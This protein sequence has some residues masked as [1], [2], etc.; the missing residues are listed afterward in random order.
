LEEK[1]YKSGFISIIG[2]PN[3]GKSE[4]L[5][6]LVGRKLSIISEKPQTTRNKI[7]GIRN[8]T[9][10]QMIFLD[11]P[12]IHM[13]RSKLNRSM[14]KIALASYQEVDI[15]LFVIDDK[16]EAG[17]IDRDVLKRLEKIDTPVFLVLN[18]IDLL[19]EKDISSIIS[20]YKEVFSFFRDIIPISALTGENLERLLKKIDE[21]LAP[22]PQYFPDDMLTDRPE[23]FIVAELIREKVIS[24]TK[25]EIPYAVAIIVESLEMKG[26]MMVIESVIFVEKE[27]QKGIIIGKGGKMLKKIGKD[28]RQ[29]IERFFGNRVYLNLWVKVRKDWRKDDKSLKEFGYH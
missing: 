2:R 9:N 29:E 25:Q 8:L 12:G 19:G 15:I 28:A 24:S 14:T 26:E 3:V 23:S 5:N 16:I 4:L 17:D 7:I 22:G 11:T 10:S 13:A 21:N 18:K 27:S 20:L 6:K 1:V